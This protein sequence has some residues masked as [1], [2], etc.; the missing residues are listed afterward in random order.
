MTSILTRHEVEPDRRTPGR[1]HAHRSWL[2]PVVTIVAI[3]LLVEV[4]TQTLDVPAYVVPAPSA[5]MEE[6][7]SNFDLLMV[8]LWATVQATLLGFLVGNA[9]AIVIAVVFVHN[10]TVER[11]V[12]PLAVMSRTIPTVAIS[13]LLVMVFGP[14]LEPKVI[15]AAL[16]CFFPTLVNMVKGF[17]SV[18]P[19]ELEL[20]RI[21]SASKSEVF[22]KLRV[23]KSTPFLFAS[24]KIAT[25]NA[26]IG[27]IVAEWI[28]SSVG[29][30]ALIVQASFNFDAPLLYAAMLVASA[31][32]LLFFA[33]IGLVEK[34]VVRWDVSEAKRGV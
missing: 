6:V 20:F 31:F 8:N 21:M 5:V 26:A 19:N 4:A 16:I 32:A 25:T 22:L 30:G 17:E 15:I 2:D 10:K 9:L 13:P 34:W 18:S 7:A 3:T 24:L 12:Y 28:G 1:L 27:A 33:V 29:I 11:S 14:E 23:Y